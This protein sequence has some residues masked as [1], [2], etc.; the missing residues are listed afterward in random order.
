ML[1]GIDEVGRGAWAGPVVVGAVSLE[2]TIGGLNDSKLL[3]AK[4]RVEL[5]KEIKQK[6]LFIG[7]GWASSSEVDD[8]GLSAAL[9]LAAHRALREIDNNEEI[10]IDGNVNFLKEYYPNSKCIIKADRTIPSVSAA[11]I[12]AKVARDEYMK[13]LSKKFPNYDFDKNVGYGTAGHK[14]SI[15]INGLCHEHRLSFRPISGLLYGIA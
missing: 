4:Q 7:I 8:Y 5:A 3:T 13:D 10:I 6:A 14:T 11:S 9:T 1:I 15:A 12:V 2:A